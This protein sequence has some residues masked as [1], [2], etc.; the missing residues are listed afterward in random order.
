MATN[1]TTLFSSIAAAIRNKTG[2]TDKI[3]ASDFPSAIDAIENTATFNFDGTA[4]A[5]D[6][7]EGKTAYTN[8]PEKVTGTIKDGCFPA[9]KDIFLAPQITCTVSPSTKNLEARLFYQDSSQRWLIDQTTQIGIP[10][11]AITSVYK[12]TADKIAKGNAIAGV[13]GTAETIATLG[14]NMNLSISSESTSDPVFPSQGITSNVDV[15]INSTE[16]IKEEDFS[17][18][19]FID[20]SYKLIFYLISKKNST[21][22]HVF[23]KATIFNYGS[24]DKTIHLNSYMLVNPKILSQ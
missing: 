7:L 6:I 20:E 16:V 22:Q 17:G 2:S 13:A 24:S 12:I 14:S 11:G 3:K 19:L 23:H 1:L 15:V 4:T 5:A 10:V 9:H 18:M 21:S 8:G